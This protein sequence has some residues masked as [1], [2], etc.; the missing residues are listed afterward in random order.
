MA[1]KIACLSASV[2]PCL[3][4]IETYSGC[5]EYVR[6]L[7]A[8]TIFGFLICLCFSAFRT[9]SEVFLKSYDDYLLN[10]TGNL[11]ILST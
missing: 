4:L 8:I 3:Q 5:I 9:R 6:D 7:L 10:R 11:E 2:W 1:A